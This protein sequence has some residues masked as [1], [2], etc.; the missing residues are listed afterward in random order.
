MQRWAPRPLGGAVAELARHPDRV[1]R[2]VQRLFGSSD[3]GRAVARTLGWARLSTGE[4]E[5][6]ELRTDRRTQ[7]Q[8]LRVLLCVL[9]EADPR[10]RCAAGRRLWQG[11]RDRTTA[12]EGADRLRWRIAGRRG[13]AA[14]AS[15]ST[16]Q[17]QRYLLCF[18]R[19][20][21][22]RR[23]QPPADMV[24]QRLR[25]ENHAYA[26]YQFSELPRPIAERLRA[27]RTG[28]RPPVAPPP[29]PVPCEAPGEPPRWETLV[30]AIGAV[31]PPP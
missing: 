7:A 26:V 20:G 11:E 6:T 28:R 29:A 2:V 8:M 18:E 30:A 12:P 15:V 14:R 1:P 25:G 10:T 31:G 24:A 21:V 13:L 23:R 3:M 22:L 17:L 4:L 19:A 9:S 16:R 5:R 27:W